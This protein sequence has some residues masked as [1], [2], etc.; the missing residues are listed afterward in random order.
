MRILLTFA[1][2]LVAVSPCQATTWTIDYLVAGDM[3][4]FYGDGTYLLLS[5]RPDIPVYLHETNWVFQGFYGEITLPETFPAIGFP[6]GIDQI[7][8]TPVS[9]GPTAVPE[10][11]TWLL[12]GVG[13]AGLVGAR[14]RQRV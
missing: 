10:P 13:L 5:P 7:A 4:H 8:V 6:I 2:L 12:V 1:V 3:S 11:A 9:S 14:R